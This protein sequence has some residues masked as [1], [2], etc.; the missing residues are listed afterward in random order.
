MG[1]IVNQSVEKYD[2][3]TGQVR[4]ILLAA[5]LAGWLAGWMWDRPCCMA[6]E[7]ASLLYSKPPPPIVFI[8]KI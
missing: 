3:Q 2:G 6:F 1:C 4:P 5:M 7:L 8:F